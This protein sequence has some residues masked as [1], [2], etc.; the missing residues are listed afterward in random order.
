MEQDFVTCPSI[1]LLFLFKKQFGVHIYVASFSGM[2][3]R[4]CPFVIIYRVF[5]SIDMFYID[6]MLMVKV[7]S[8]SG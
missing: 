4:G 5:L 1:A 6:K 7:A 3:I 8:M 2:S